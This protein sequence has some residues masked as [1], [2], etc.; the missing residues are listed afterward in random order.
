MA[1]KN[2]VLNGPSTVILAD[3]RDPAQSW[4]NHLNRTSGLRGGVDLVAPIGTPVYAPTAGTWRWL[5][6]NG[7]AGNSGQFSHDANP[8]WRDVF[9]H[10]SRYVGWS[11][12]HFTQGQIIAYTGNTG[13]VVQH[14]HRHLLDPQ[15][16]RRNPW[17]Y[18][19]ASSTAALSTTL[20][21]EQDDDMYILQ[22]PAPTGAIYLAGPGAVIH[23]QNSADHAILRRLVA[24]ETIFTLAELKRIT[25]YMN[26]FEKSAS[27]I[28]PAKLAAELAKAGVT[29]NVDTAALA[30]A[31]DAS[32]RDDFAAIP[33]AV[34]G[35]IKA[36]L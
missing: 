33:G 20:I 22:D 36:A 6:N 10:L 2:Y 27:T 5:K 15:G 12:K 19:T 17:L 31:L 24:R 8:G 1:L 7:G 16:N 13:G 34:V 23:I 28:D 18:F 21:T 9:S 11:G 32:L 29:A 35:G 4:R 25:Y 30:K 14:L 3:S 26:A